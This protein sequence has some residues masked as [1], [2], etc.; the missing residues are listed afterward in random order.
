MTGRAFILAAIL[1]GG[2]LI[3]ST[4]AA[5]AADVSLA[6]VIDDLGYSLQ[7]AERVMA[8][9]APVTLAV[10]PFAPETPAILDRARHTGHEII[11]HQP[12]EALPQSRVTPIPGLLTVDMSAGHFESLMDAAL[13]AVP[14]IVGVNNHTG[15]RLTQDHAAMRRLMDLLKGRNLLFLDSRTT[16]ATVAYAMAREA[17]IPAIE[18]DV[19]LDHV[20]RRD[21]IDREFRR[22]L[23]IARR[24]GHAVLIAHPYAVSLDYLE[25]ALAALPP[26]VEVT[27]LRRLADRDPV[28]LARRESPEFPRRSLGQ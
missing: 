18:R 21:A 14:G 19:F 23:A 9:P 13:R 1:A 4:G 16:P 3:R 11:L 24:N 15:S 2:L 17:R 7:R 5:E 22:A 12:M 6:V 8:L 20:P 26:D 27:S 25:E 10:L 28:T